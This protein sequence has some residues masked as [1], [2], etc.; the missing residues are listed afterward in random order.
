MFFVCF[1]FSVYNENKNPT[2]LLVYTFTRIVLP[3]RLATVGEE[4]GHAISVYTQK[5][6]GDKDREDSS[7]EGER[8][9]QKAAHRSAFLRALVP[10]V[11]GSEQRLPSASP[12]I[13]FFAH[14]LSDSLTVSR[15]LVAI[16][17]DDRQE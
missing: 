17:S 16:S 14:R 12:G 13:C 9:I 8:N 11:W 1:V 6:G 10:R 15:T 2:S 3:P 7:A 5:G 4:G